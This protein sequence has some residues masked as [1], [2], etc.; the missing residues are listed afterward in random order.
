MY[1]T[2]TLIGALIGFTIAWV[3]R[4]EPLILKY[5]IAKPVLWLSLLVAICRFLALWA[6]AKTVISKAH[7]MNV[8]N[9]GKAALFLLVAFQ[10]V[11]LIRAVK[12]NI[13]AGAFNLAIGR[14]L[15]LTVW[16]AVITCTSFFFVV[17]IGKMRNAAEMEQFFIQSGYPAS[18]NYVIIGV[19]CVFSLAM[20][21]HY[22]LRT[23]LVSAIVLMGVMLGAIITHAKNGDPLEA[24]Y[25][26]FA[27]LLILCLLTAL[28]IVEKRYAGR[29]LPKP[30]TE[31]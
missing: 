7:L 1:F 6:D 29:N 30:V 10:T 17:S 9:W 13:R 4:I 3:P 20:I 8:F 27:Q 14:L 5:K 15:R 23:G 16:A 19:E 28:F 22:K 25:D 12:G 24:S 31:P 26:A 11:A 21:W 18:F 2:I